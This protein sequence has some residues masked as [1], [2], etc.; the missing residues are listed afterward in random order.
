MRE[1][2]V[3]PEGAAPPP[4]GS[5]PVKC[6][7]C[8]Y[9]RAIA[10]ADKVVSADGRVE[11]DGWC[12]AN[13]PNVSVRRWPVGGFVIE[14]I[15]PPTRAGDLCRHW[16]AE[17]AGD[18]GMPIAEALEGMAEDV[19]ALVQYMREAVNVGRRRA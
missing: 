2:L 7:T 5:D 6:E 3:I 4:G 10:G 17:F 19:A 11:G 18:A 1:P 13:P 14:P 8:V 15:R 16:R 12:Y 9:F